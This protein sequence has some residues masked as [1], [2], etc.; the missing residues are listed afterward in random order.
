MFPAGGCDP[1]VWS[2]SMISEYDNDVV[3]D[4]AASMAACGFVVVFPLLVVVRM[5]F[6]EKI[7]TGTARVIFLSKMCDG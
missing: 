3:G 5:R 1:K 4:G 7:L 2:Q 6:V